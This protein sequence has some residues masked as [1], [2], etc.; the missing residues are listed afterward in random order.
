MHST[1]RHETLVHR[2]YN[3]PEPWKGRLVD[4]QSGSDVLLGIHMGKPEKEEMLGF[5]SSAVKKGAWVYPTEKTA[6]GSLMRTV[7]PET[8]F[9]VPSAKFKDSMNPLLSPSKNS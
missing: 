1:V 5:S 3:V 6:L 7:G 2:T 9:M 8:I 4:G